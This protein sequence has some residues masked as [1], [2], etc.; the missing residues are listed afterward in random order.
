MFWPEP[1]LE[2]V[3]V[4]FVWSKSTLNK[5]TIEQKKLKNWKKIPV[6][7]GC[8]ANP[9]KAKFWL[10]GVNTDRKFRLRRQQPALYVLSFWSKRCFSQHPSSVNWENRRSESQ[11][12]LLFMCSKDESD[13][14]LQKCKRLSWYTVTYGG[15]RGIRL[16]SKWQG[17]CLCGVLGVINHQASCCFSLDWH[18]GW[19]WPVRR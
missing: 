6:E 11:N 13:P 9:N 16:E 18:F 19:C 4:V 17:R 8:E 10:L 14:T 7:K 3:L 5:P 2:I 12:H 15:Y 1:I